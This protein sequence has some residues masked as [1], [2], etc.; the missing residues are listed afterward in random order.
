MEIYQLRYF[1]AVAETGNFT[2]AAARSFISQPSLSQQILNLEEE[3][4]QKL[5]HRLGR[6]VT[7]TNAGHLLLERAHRILAEADDAVRELKEDPALGHRVSVGVIPTVAHF[8]LPAVLAHC[9]TNDILLQ[10]HTRED[11]RPTVVQAVL[12]GDMDLGVVSMPVNEPRIETSLLF[13]EPLLLAVSASH[14]LASAASVTLEDLREQDFVMLGTGSST[15]TLVQRL[16]GDHDFEPRVV[17]RAAQLSTA[18]AL[19]ALGVGISVLPRSARTANDPAGLVYR[20]FSGQVPMRE[21]SLIRHYR[22]HHTKGAKLFTDAAHA[23]VGPMQATGTTP[24]FRPP[25]APRS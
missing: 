13:S 21:I 4:G 8:F 24:P 10:L 3:L 6:K 15:A 17:H 5:F 14:P 16:L 19:V 9:R 18:K 11:F 22:H 20:K 23:V 12:D 2:K 7:L 25:S 1:I